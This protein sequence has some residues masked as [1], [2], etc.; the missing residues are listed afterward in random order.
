MDRRLIKRI[1]KEAESD[2]I[3]IGMRGMH[4]S[5]ET[6]IKVASWDKRK[7]ESILK[8]VDR[9]SEDIQQE[10][11]KLKNGNFRTELEKA[12]ADPSTLMVK[13][14]ELSSHLSSRVF[15]IQKDAIPIVMGAYGY[16]QSLRD[17]ITRRRT[18][19]YVLGFTLAIMSDI[20]KTI[21]SFLETVPAP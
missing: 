20:P 2:A 21:V 16:L 3:Y 15:Q 8:R 11:S 19:L 17:K 14:N 13:L 6:L 12:G 18:T 9:V 4:H 5:A 10:T 7:I 1:R